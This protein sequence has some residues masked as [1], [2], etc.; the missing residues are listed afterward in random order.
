MILSSDA[1]RLWE[2]AQQMNARSLARGPS[3][4]SAST[5]RRKAALPPLLLFTDP[6]RVPRPWELAARLP[7]G[8]GLVY[9]AFGAPDALDVAE[10]LRAM[11]RERGLILLIGRDADLADRVEAD[12][13]HLPERSASAAYALGGR[14][15]DWLLTGAVHSVTAATKARDL[16]AVVLSPIFPAGGPSSLRPALGQ[17]ALADACQRS[18]IPVYALGGVDADTAEALI[19]SGACGIAGI[20]GFVRAFGAEPVRI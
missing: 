1:R 20:G 8:A 7:P 19:N 13:V 17:D 16:D 3:S 18:A 11:T 4:V 10:R 5:A 14:R 2:A 9:R 15:P 12:G 6:D